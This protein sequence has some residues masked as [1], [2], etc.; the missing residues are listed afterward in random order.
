MPLP[1]LQKLIT[2]KTL[3]HDHETNQ[4]ALDWIEKQLKNLPLYIKKHTFNQFPSL[5]VTTQKTKNPVIWLAA[6][7]DVVDGSAD[8]FKPKITKTRIFGRGSFDMKFALACYLKLLKDLGKNLKNH[9]F[10][11]MITTDEEIGGENGV[12]ALLNQA[13]YKSKVCFLPDGGGDHWHYEQSAKGFY[14]AEVHSK[15][16]SAHGSRPWLGSNAI[17]NLINFLQTLK[18]HFPK[19]PCRLKNHFHNTLNIG[20]IAGGLAVN[21]IPDHA[22][23]HIDIRFTKN[24]A[25]IQKILTDSKKKHKNIVFRNALSGHSAKI[26]RQNEYLKIYQNIAR[27]DFKINLKPVISHGSSDARFFAAKNIPTLLISPIG[28]GR[29]SEKEW[30]DINSLGIYYQILK[31]FVVTIT[32]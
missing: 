2:F 8:L 9:N 5:I 32:R 19:E 11:L 21:Q 26:D 16:V 23:V 3:S 10:G 31:K 14:M 27:Q 12:K 24:I 25:E 29:H 30:L 1:Y 13:G 4:Q 18:S 20:K 7:L 17:E 15:G 22:S 6:H 28:G